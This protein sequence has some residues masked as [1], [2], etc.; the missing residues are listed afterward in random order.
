[1]STTLPQSFW[2][3]LKSRCGYCGQPLGPGEGSAGVCARPEC[4]TRKRMAEAAETGRRRIEEK[5]TYET[6]TKRR[7][8]PV[9]RKAAA[10]VGHD[11]LGQVAYGTAPYIE[12]PTILLPDARRATFEAHLRA[13][14]SES[15]ADT[16]AG[17]TPA[18]PDEDPDYAQRRAAEAPEDFV[19]NA[20]CIACQGD[21]C[22][23]GASRM[24][25]LTPVTVDYV[26]WCDP[27]ATAEQIVAHYL[28]AIPEASTAGS[29]VYHGAQGCTLDRGHRADICNSFQCTARQALKQQLAR[30]PGT[31][32][33]VAGMSRDHLDHPEA[34]APY[35][36]VV[37]VSAEH[38]IRVH[39]DLT[40]PA[41]RKPATR[42][43]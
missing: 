11:S 27:D 29:C 31:G 37:S 13:I 25:F 3:H 12:I 6:V 16:A 20:T 33:V 23:L 4:Q 24:A 40:L 19:L 14:V 36:R 38:K 26:R 39:S 1:M 17:E 22:L 21:C 42:P 15:F 43:D 2:Q 7:A 30:K 18:P 32:A 34:A 10:A 8:R 35:L 28:S 5:Q 9:L 41:L